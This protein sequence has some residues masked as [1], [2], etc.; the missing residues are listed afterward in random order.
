MVPDDATVLYEMWSDPEHHLIT[1]DSPMLVESLAAKRARLEKSLAE[2]DVRSARFTAETIVD[3]TVI[4]ACSLWGLDAFNQFGHLGISLLPAARTQGYGREV[5][6]LLCHY[7]F[8]FR[9]LHR[10]ELETLATN[11]AMRKLARKLRLRARR[12]PAR[13]GL[14]RRRLL[15][16]R[17]V[18]TAQAGVEP[19]EGHRP[20]GALLPSG[21]ACD[22][23]AGTF[24]GLADHHAEC[25][26]VLLR[27]RVPE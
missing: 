19:L 8:R 3:G 14:R 27:G 7:G 1:D 4:G 22:G 2:P 17:A 18:R 21:S 15:R 5:V 6:Q 26:Y 11:A 12:H 9:N 13:A 23:A 16:H 25:V 24:H 10:I 20:Q